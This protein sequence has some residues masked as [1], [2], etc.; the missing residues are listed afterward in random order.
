MAAQLL[1]GPTGSQRSSPSMHCCEQ[2]VTLWISFL[3]LEAMFVLSMAPVF[4]WDTCAT[5]LCLLHL[6][7]TVAVL[8]D[9]IKTRQDT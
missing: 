6:L 4:L 5:F 3:S 8:I 9:F 7:T 1:P 2:Q